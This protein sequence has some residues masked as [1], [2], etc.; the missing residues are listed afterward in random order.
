MELKIN[1]SCWNVSPKWVS[2]GPRARRSAQPFARSAQPFFKIQIQTSMNMRENHIVAME[3]TL[4]M[5]RD[6]EFFCTDKN[7]SDTLSKV[8]QLWPVLEPDV[9]RTGPLSRTGPHERKC[10]SAE[11]SGPVS[12]DASVQLSD[13]QPV[14]DRDD[15][16]WLNS[17]GSV[18]EF[19][20]RDTVERLMLV[21]L[22]DSELDKLL[23]SENWSTAGNRSAYICSN[24]SNSL[25][26]KHRLTNYVF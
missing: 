4:Q 14:D 7:A 25:L 12:A 5:T 26:R 15:A 23:V 20:S 9:S 3:I 2:R 8:T 19:F 21:A 1:L 22:K 6:R 10:T 18:G 17:K 24:S 16:V 13:S 11:K